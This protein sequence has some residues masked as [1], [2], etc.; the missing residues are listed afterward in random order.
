MGIAPDRVTT[1]GL[2]SYARAIRTVV[3]RK[4]RNRT[5]HYLKTG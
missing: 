5:G 1:D 3:G 4:V 2:G